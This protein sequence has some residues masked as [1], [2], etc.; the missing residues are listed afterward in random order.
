MTQPQLVKARTHRVHALN[1]IEAMVDLGFGIHANKMFE[2]EDVNPA[3]ARGEYD[4]A[5]HCFAVL[6]GGK[7]LLI[8]P[9]ERQRE[10]WTHAPVLRARIYLAE[11]THGSQVG[12]TF[13]LGGRVDP[14]LEVAPFVNWLRE[15]SF[16]L[17]DV[18]AALNGLGSRNGGH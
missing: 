11:K 9:D 8:Q 6:L 17:D 16:R 14:V 15:R 3:L 12:H 18:K 5:M 7:H 1:R 4:R 10:E 2:I 13:G